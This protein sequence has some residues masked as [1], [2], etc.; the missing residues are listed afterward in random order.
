KNG[1]LNGFDQRCLANTVGCDDKGHRLRQIKV[2][3]LVGA[4]VRESDPANHEKSA[5]KSSR[6]R[7]INPSPSSR[8]VRTSWMT[9]SNG[10]AL[11]YFRPT[12]AFFFAGI[13]A[14]RP[15]LSLSDSVT[16]AMTSS[17]A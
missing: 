10:P 2:Q 14:E 8:P 4:P 17:S 6:S 15:R 9:D 1:P 7:R 16:D 3:L 11:R 12:S 5:S 13:F